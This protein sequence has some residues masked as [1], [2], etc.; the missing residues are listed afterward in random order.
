MQWSDVI[1]SLY[2]LGH[3]LY[4]SSQLETLK[5]FLNKDKSQESPCPSDKHFV[6]IIYMDIIGLNQMKRLTKNGFLKY[7][8]HVRVLDSFGT[9]PAFNYKPYTT[10]H[11]LK[12]QWGKQ[13]LVPQ[14]F[15][16]MFPHTPDN[17]FMGFVVDTVDPASVSD[18]PR[19]NTSLVYAKEEYMW[20][21]KQK[22]LDI[23]SEFTEIHATVHL[24]PK[25]VK[26]YIPKYV[27]NHGILSSHDLQQLQQN[28]KL[29][30]G[31]GFPYEGPAPLEAVANGCVF[32]NPS[33]NPPKNRKN[34]KFF[35]EKPTFRQL[36]SQNPYAEQY[37]GK[38]HV[39]TVDINNADKLRLAI[40]EALSTKVS[41]YLPKEF[42][43]E[44]MLQ[45]LAVYTEKQD[46]C[47]PDPG[48]WPPKKA[49]QV[50]LSQ[51]GESCN[52]VC[53]KENLI[54]ERS[55][56]PLLN[57]EEELAMHNVRCTG[58]LYETDILNPSFENLGETCSLQK[59]Q[60]LFSCAGDNV[61]RHRV[62]PCRDFIHGQTA[63]CK[64][65]L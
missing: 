4:V 48:S 32:I 13:N 39:F 26:E 22:Y 31:L 5:A 61:Q 9:E 36:T 49:M 37:I 45:R 40:K 15:F 11:H 53:Q 24:K 65:C 6:D 20:E 30:I 21:G 27:I 55:F 63:F 60:L 41:A 58:A 47:N 23:I 8:C 25:D 12:T 19:P 50:F 44:G 10:S 28:T 1:A 46:F 17:S 29:F 43:M 54:C 34:T 38:P 16:T 2:L 14:Q 35:S 51:K 3:D 52:S 18:A 33:F 7:S 62:C 57:T 64:A 59:Q 42:Q 56:F